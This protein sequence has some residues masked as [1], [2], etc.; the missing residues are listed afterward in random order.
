MFLYNNGYDPQHSLLS[1]GLVSKVLSIKEGI[2]RGRSR[3]DFL[4]GDEEYKRRLGG[5]EVSLYGCQ[6]SLR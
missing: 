1:L 3:F 4:K 2:E 6:I 5:K